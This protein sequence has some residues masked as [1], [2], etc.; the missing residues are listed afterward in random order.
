MQM[1]RRRPALHAKSAGI[2]TPSNDIDAQLGEELHSRRNHQAVRARDQDPSPARS[3]D[4][5]RSFF[6]DRFDPTANEKRV[7]DAKA[8]LVFALRDLSEMAPGE[9]DQR[10]GPRVP[11]DCKECE[12][13]QNESI[14]AHERKRSGERNSQCNGDSEDDTRSGHT[15]GKCNRGAA[16]KARGS[17]RARFSD[18]RTSTILFDS[19]SV[20]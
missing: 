18:Q 13:K 1:P 15:I 5:I 8:R 12:S 16:I 20:P 9:K 10:P 14:G 19:V 4:G 17:H 11:R 6:A 7:G 2:F 3:H